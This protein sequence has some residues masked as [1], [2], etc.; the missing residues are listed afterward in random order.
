[1]TL[2]LGSG[3]Y[4]VPEFRI[5]QSSISKPLPLTQNNIIRYIPAM[6]Q[7]KAEAIWKEVQSLESFDSCWGFSRWDLRGDLRHHS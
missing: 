2:I 6:V 5:G 1:M 7:S 4:K 3:G